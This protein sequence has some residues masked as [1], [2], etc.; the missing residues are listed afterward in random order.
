MGNRGS[1]SAKDS[2][3]CFAAG[4]SELVAVCAGDLSDQGVSPEQAKFAADPGRATAALLF[5]GSSFWK[6]DGE[7]I[8]PGFWGYW[9]SQIPIY[10][11]SLGSP[12]TRNSVSASTTA[13][14]LL[15]ASDALPFLANGKPA[16][17]TTS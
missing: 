13:H 16:R 11:F 5:V 4:G 12:R 10:G 15:S 8:W 14:T 3:D 2:D 17:H 7:D 9:G 1:K 6:E